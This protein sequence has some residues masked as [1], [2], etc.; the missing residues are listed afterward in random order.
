[1]KKSKDLQ[2]CINV[3]EL[4]QRQDGKL[5][6]EQRSLVDNAL[7]SLRSFRRKSKPSN[8]EIYEL[9]RKV[10]QILVEIFRNDKR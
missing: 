6:S 3:L 2:F 10:S 8:A 9:V 7:K 5:G 1:M 4:M